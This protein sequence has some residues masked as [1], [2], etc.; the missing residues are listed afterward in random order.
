MNTSV[1]QYWTTG[2]AL[3]YLPSA[4]FGELDFWGDLSCYSIACRCAARSTGLRAAAPQR[5]SGCQPSRPVTAHDGPCR[6]SAVRRTADW[7][8]AQHVTCCGWRLCCV[9][10]DSPSHRSDGSCYW[11]MA[12]PQEQGCFNVTRSAWICE[13][14]ATRVRL[15]CSGILQ[16]IMHCRLFLA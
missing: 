6:L 9:C 13:N 5:F 4:F 1:G 8:P 14:G 10:R 11:S 3:G 16:G 7:P 12:L 2:E 15:P